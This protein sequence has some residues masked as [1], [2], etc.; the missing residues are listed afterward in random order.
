MIA[1][2]AEELTEAQRRTVL[3]ACFLAWTFAG[4]EISLY[5]LVGP[6]ALRDILRTDAGGVVSKTAVASW[7]NGFACAFLLGAAAGGWLFGWLGD[8]FGR[9]PALGWS[10][11]IY[12]AFTG[13]GY[14]YSDPAVLVGLRFVACLGIGGTWPNAVALASEAWPGVARPTLAGLLGSAANF[15]FVGLGLLA[16][17]KKVTPESW[18]WT[19]A[20]SSMPLLLGIYCL[21]AVP[22]SPRWKSSRSLITS[23]TNS[24]RTI[25]ERPL[26][27]RTLLGIVL[28]GVPVVGTAVSANWLQPWVD[29][30]A[31]LDPHLKAWTQVTRSSGAIIGSFLGGWLASWAGRRRSYFLMCVVSL[32]VSEI[33]FLGLMPS[34]RFFFAWVFVLGAVGVTFF[35]WL[36]LCL[37]E[38]FPTAV[39]ATGMGVT[40]N[41]G[42]I[43]AAAVAMSA[44]GVIHWTG[45]NYPA[46]GAAT[47]LIYLVGMVA[48]FWL[49][50]SRK[51]NLE[52]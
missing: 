35:G 36:P 20:W 23:S 42:R 28:G 19:I 15:G 26:L 41:S 38:M 1:I 7:F 27:W 45:G 12:S 3:L 24:L 40:F 18:R 29:A 43:V 30:V 49:P 48:I 34:D 39:R 14:F 46:I 33:I 22:E 10:V 6:T 17:W 51:L 47:S 25:F 44:S 32:A 52:D 21:F 13:V 8:R 31:P 50:D 9:R 37:P 2:R 11:I 5:S 4:W 16:C